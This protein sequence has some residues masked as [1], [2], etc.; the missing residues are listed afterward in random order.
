MHAGALPVC[1]HGAQQIEQNCQ[2]E[3]CQAS[4]SHD[5]ILNMGWEGS[6]MLMKMEDLWVELNNVEGRKHVERQ[7]DGC[8]G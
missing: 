5:I 4:P 8:E 1:K 6:Q 2:S 7:G 3:N